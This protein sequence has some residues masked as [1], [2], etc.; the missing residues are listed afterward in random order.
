MSKAPHNPA[1]LTEAFSRNSPMGRRNTQPSL[2]RW[3]I[4]QTP[5][6]ESQMRAAR[7]SVSRWRYPVWGTMSRSPTRRV[8]ASVCCSRSRAIGMRRSRNS[9]VKK[10]G[11]G[12][13]LVV[14]SRIIYGD[15]KMQ[16]ITA[17]LWFNDQAE[18]AA[19][20]YT[21]IFTNATIGEITHYGEGSP[22]PKG[23]VLTVRFQLDGH[24]FL[25]LNGGLPCTF[26]EA[27]SFIVYCET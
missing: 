7:C 12:F 23:S 26:T 11:R 24:E 5:S 27:V 4:S 20:F 6:G 14:F 9:L 2:L 3:K 21:T 22:R 17:C 15:A 16:K 10:G 19:R 1:R 13:Q 8:T 25:A 18:E